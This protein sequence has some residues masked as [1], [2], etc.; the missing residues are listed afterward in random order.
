MVGNQNHGQDEGRVQVG[1][2]RPVLNQRQVSGNV[3][4]LAAGDVQVLPNGSLN[5]RRMELLHDC[6]VT[7]GCP[8]IFVQQAVDDVFQQKRFVHHPRSTN[9]VAIAIG[10]CGRGSHQYVHRSIAK[11]ASD[12]EDFETA[13]HDHARLLILLV[14]AA[15]FVHCSAVMHEV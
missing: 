12:L 5:R 4:V 6:R 1:V 15:R 10:H 2:T 3:L 11:D 8:E 14:V 7:P 13:G 9:S